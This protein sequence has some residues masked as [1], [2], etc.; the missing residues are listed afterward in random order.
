MI[1]IELYRR[2]LLVSLVRQAEEK[3]EV[4][5]SGFLTHYFYMQFLSTED[6]D[7]F[8]RIVDVEFLREQIELNSGRA[9]D[10]NVE[11]ILQLFD[12]YNEK[13]K[14]FKERLSDEFYD[15]V[16]SDDTETIRLYQVNAELNSEMNSLNRK[17]LIAEEPFT[18]PTMK[19]YM[20]FNRSVDMKRLFLQ[21]YRYQTLFKISR[22]TMQLSTSDRYYRFIE[23]AFGVDVECFASPFNRHLKLYCS[24]F[25]DVDDSVGSYFAVHNSLFDGKSRSAS[26]DCPYQFHIIDK[27]IDLCEDTLEKNEAVGCKNIFIFI[28]PYW[29]DAKF[30]DRLSS[31]RFAKAVGV[32][33]RDASTFELHLLERSSLLHIQ[34]CN[35]FAVILSNDHELS[36]SE[37]TKRKWLSL[38]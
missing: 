25:P 2:R 38:I 27:T 11:F 14:S 7:P 5:R 29:K 36:I 16:Y 23:R 3:C 15:V 28:L 1:E 37:S 6:R 18:H 31:S 12:R 21:V 33:P 34:P 20:R 10:E 26:F 9:T 17:A 22:T 35:T 30:V 13:M 32:V 19:R 8:A 24:A 4:K